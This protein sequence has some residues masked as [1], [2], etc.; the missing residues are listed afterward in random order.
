MLAG[1]Q[2][3]AVWVLHSERAVSL[4]FAALIAPALVAAPIWGVMAR[5]N[6]KERVFVNASVLFGLAALSMTLLLWMP[7][8]WVYVSVAVAGFAY[9]GMQ[10]MP[11]AMLPDV[12]SH[13]AKTKGDGQ[14]GAFSGVWTAGETAGMAL[15]ATVLTIM[16]TVTGYVESTAGVVVEQSPT[17]VAG[18]IVSFSIVP[19]VLVAVSLVSL[20]RY[21]LRRDEIDS[22]SGSGSG[23]AATEGSAATQGAQ[24]A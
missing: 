21:R 11:M 24:D 18:I 4:L 5:R 8:D 13:D 20:A 10:S 22:G 6:G 3:V 16:L 7:G 23:D 2:Y 9:A 17:A 14:A 12:I 1:A 19:A 15:G